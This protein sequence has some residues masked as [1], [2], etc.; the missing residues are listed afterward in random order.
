MPA[1]RNAAVQKSTSLLGEELGWGPE[2]TA[3]LP[4]YR[5]T[6]ICRSTSFSTGVAPASPIPSTASPTASPVTLSGR[7]SITC[8]NSTTISASRHSPA[9]P[10]T[11]PPNTHPPST[12]PP[13]TPPPAAHRSPAKTAPPSPPAPTPPP[14]PPPPTRTAIPLP[15]PLPPEPVRPAPN[16]TSPPLRAASPRH[17]QD[18]PA[19]PS[20]SF[21]ISGIEHRGKAA[22]ELHYSLTTGPLLSRLIV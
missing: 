15:P 5:P 19:A 2:A 22:A 12:P 21:Q 20:I 6:K 17:A 3:N 4:T 18:L 10:R 11:P 13:P 8:H 9:A 7:P 14:P 1:N 16:D